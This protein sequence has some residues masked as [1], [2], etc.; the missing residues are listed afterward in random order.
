MAWNEPGGPKKDDPWGKPKN[1]QSGP[2]DLDEVVRNLQN[3]LAGLFGRKGGGGGG[4]SGG[5]G[6]G[7]VSLPRP[8]G[9]GMWIVI[10]V[11]VAFIYGYQCFYVVAPAERA[12]VL[13]FGKLVD[14]VQA[15]PHWAW[16][17]I[18]N[19]TIE[20]VD[21]IRTAELGYR[22][23]GRNQQ[24]TATNAKEALMLTRDENIIDI[25]FAVQYKIKDLADFLFR[26]VDPEESLRQATE[27][28][29]R[30]IVGKSDMDFVLTEG[31]SDIAV[32]V[33]ALSQE[34]LDR[35]KTGLQVTSVNMQSA[36][37]PEEVQGAFDDAVKAREDQQRLI[38]EAEAYSNDIL[39]R[40]RGA[41]ARQLEEA[42]AY[43]NQ[44]TAQAE[45]EAA[46]FSQILTE[47][48]KAPE[49]TRKRL[50]LEV[51]EGVMRDTN[52]VI[53]DVK[54]GN[55]VMFLP[56]DRLATGASSGT[57]ATASSD[58]FV[59]DAAAIAPLVP[60]LENRTD[61]GRSD[62]RGRETR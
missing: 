48:A 30:E 54:S 4:Q 1:D 43:K 21:Q 3:K 46:R 51:V 38:N 2:P 41:A 18:E 22:S 37:A 53:V 19:V 14:T 17:P 25:K 55:N 10:G 36:Q 39:P 49:V 35:Y 26:V 45:G 8:G 13:R 5:G 32:R 59:N 7:G 28:A 12:V 31:R 20:N 42:N 33:A 15:G 50:Y 11:F 44:V 58:T 52:K 62:T 27:S 16:F 40:A 9:S 57:A 23:S 6:G 60:Q 56:L 29:V 34:I 24:M 47:Y 61:R